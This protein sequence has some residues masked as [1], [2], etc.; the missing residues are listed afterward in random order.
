MWALPHKTDS[1]RSDTIWTSP[2]GRFASAV[3][4]SFP[5]SPHPQLSCGALRPLPS[6]V[7][8]WTLSFTTPQ[9]SRTPSLATSVHFCAGHSN[10]SPS[11]S[12]SIFEARFR[13]AR[14]LWALSV[15]SSH[16]LKSP[17]VAAG[18]LFRHTGSLGQK[19]GLGPLCRARQRWRRTLETR[20]NSALELI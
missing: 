6:F 14:L 9:T 11:P 20:E 2:L 12:F 13:G 10:F 5:S 18:S 16:C 7:T 8:S 3:L 15:S 19:A 4:H 1:S 17:C